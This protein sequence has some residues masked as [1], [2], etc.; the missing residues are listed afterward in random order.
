M[1]AQ[2]NNS[3]EPLVEP[4]TRREREILGLLAEGH[5]APEMAQQLHLAV[6][7]VKWHQQQLYGKLGVNSKQ[8]ALQRAA[9]LG[10]LEITP[11]AQP[12]PSAPKH[13]LP[14]Q[15]TRFFGREAEIAQLK[16]RLAQH[17]LVTLAGSGGVGKT[18]LSL[19][20]A[21][22]LLGGFADGVWFVALAPLTDP[23]LV[24]P[25]V[26]AVLGL[27]GEAGQP[28]VEALIDYLRRRQVLLVLDNCEH[29]LEAC[30]QLVDGLVRACSGVTVLAS[31]REPL[32]IEGEAV[33]AVPS[34]PFPTA[35]TPIQ[36][37]GLADYAA[38]RL[39]LDRVKLTLPNYAVTANNAAA[40]ARICQRLDGI[41][42]ALELAAARLRLLDAETLA[43]RLDDVFGLLTGGS[44][45]ALPRQQTLRATMDWSY[46]LLTD[47]ERLLLQRLSVF[48]GGCTLEAA[49][50][51]C[52]G[53]GLEAGQVLEVLG[54]L[55]AKSMV[56]A[57]HQPGA[58]LRYRLLE[59]VRQYARDK[60][61]EAG[62]APRR[63]RYHR[64]YFLEFAE[65]NLSKLQTVARSAWQ[66]K[67]EAERD[68]FRLA[69]EW[70]FTDLG[71]PDAGPRLL[72]VAQSVDLYPY[73]EACDWANR[74][75]ALCRSRAEI[76]T[77]L[78]I[79][80]LELVGHLVSGPDPDG[81]LSFMQQ[82]VSLAR[83]MGPDGQETLMW[84]LFDLCLAYLNIDAADDASA[85]LDEAEA[86]LQ[87]LGPVRYLPDEFLRVRAYF[88]VQK[89]RIAYVRDQFALSKQLSWECVRLYEA[90]GSRWFA[91]VGYTHLGVTCI[92]LG[93]YVEAMQHLLTASE[94]S[95]EYGRKPT[96]YLAF[97]LAR[98]A[99]HLDRLREAGEYCLESLRLANDELDMRWV[100]L[101]T[102][103]LAAISA[104]RGERARAAR[105][106]GVA[107]AVCAKCRPKFSSDFP[108][109]KI[110][111]GWR[112]APDSQAIQEAYDAGAAMSAN[113][114][115][116]FALADDAA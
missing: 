7:S 49:E 60:L 67:I 1:S 74:G 108:L 22:E 110:L 46:R 14:L 25:T 85:A 35:G 115:M 9:E 82:A 10:L 79:K 13:N 45:T 48:A 23:A 91:H 100:G 113:E 102:A 62:A 95:H 44:R 69:L 107:E 27:R 8:A 12:H 84:S 50:A 6:S 4:L 68:N 104:K 66:P 101:N 73:Q 32:G 42:L 61:T 33:V 112:E 77:W 111:L 11:A 36:A 97:W 40:L 89:A 38:V 2:A 90:S 116:A 64:D 88:A 39:F 114:A 99:Y 30:A 18:R 56:T 34:L 63:R 94:R 37:D 53:E 31:S 16:A 19:R 71:V 24:A 3:V 105:L 103:L 26:A 28:V 29:V 78:H 92:S 20:T 70:S 17:R 106:A 109:D 59:T 76:P 55:V 52:S 86:I 96:V 54:A 72:L 58:A 57:D 87:S 75:L 83:T 21:E 43:A 65:A 5:S 15:I 47:E 51:V 98:A 93:E 80:L 81:A 41:P